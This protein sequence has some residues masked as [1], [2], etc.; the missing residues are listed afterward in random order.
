MENILLNKQLTRLGYSLHYLREDPCFD[1]TMLKG[2]C[3]LTNNNVLFLG[4]EITGIAKNKKTNKVLLFT[5]QDSIANSFREYDVVVLE[6][7][8][9]KYVTSLYTSNSLFFESLID[10]L[11]NKSKDKFEHTEQFKAAGLHFTGE[12]F[13]MDMTI[14]AG[15]S[16]FVI[17]KKTKD[18]MILRT[19]DAVK[20]LLHY[21]KKLTAIDMTACTPKGTRKVTIEG[22]LPYIFKELVFY[23]NRAIIAEYLGEGN[24]IRKLYIFD[25][26]VVDVTEPNGNTV[27]IITHSINKLPDQYPVNIYIESVSYKELID[28]TEDSIVSQGYTPIKVRR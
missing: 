25:K 1:L 17:N 14:D 8:I 23:F 11:A 4:D 27:A 19:L 22:N 12:E 18:T 28:R 21:M 2:T 15:V 5:N 20:A 16:A 6:G 3:V 9:K 7:E 24:T 26:H 13:C 10:L